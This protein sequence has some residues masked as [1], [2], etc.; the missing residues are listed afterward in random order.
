MKKIKKDM[1]IDMFH[2]G[3]SSTPIPVFTTANNAEKNSTPET[4]VPEVSSDGNNIPNELIKVDFDKQTVSARALYDFFAPT[5]RF[6]PWFKRMFSYGL[7]ENIDFT[8]AK[9]FLSVNNGAKQ[10]IGDYLLTIDAAK[11]IAM[12]QRNEKGKQARQYFINIEKLFGKS[13]ANAQTTSVAN[14]QTTSVAAVPLLENL[15]S[16]AAQCEI[17]LQQMQKDYASKNEVLENQCL[18]LSQQKNQQNQKIERSVD[19]FS[20]KVEIALKDWVTE[21]ANKGEGS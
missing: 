10:D 15:K 12:V 3:T 16:I 20:Q 1:S 7:T 4:K 6:Y 13:V 19:F 17:Y 8:A 2:D 18:E 9:F 11:H 21:V 5:E 14:A